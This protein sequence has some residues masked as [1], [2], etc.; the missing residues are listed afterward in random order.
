MLVDMDAPL[1]LNAVTPDRQAF[2]TTFGREVSNHYICQRRGIL[3]PS[4]SCGL[5]L[6]MQF[7]TGQL[8][9]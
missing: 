6:F 3:N 1:I 2:N 8:Y 5:Q 9:E 4:T 7:I